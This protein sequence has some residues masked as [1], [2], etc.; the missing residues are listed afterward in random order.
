MKL[1]TRRAALRAAQAVAGLTVTVV[2]C[3]PA[4]PPEA[5][6]VPAS[7]VPIRPVGPP[8]SLSATPSHEPC[9]V[10]VD[11]FFPGEDD[12]Q[13]E[14]HI[15]APPDVERCCL[16]ALR[17]QTTEATTPDPAG[18]LI[19]NRHRWACCT[20]VDNPKNSGL[21][22]ACTPWGPPVPPPMRRR[23]LVS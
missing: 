17:H 14:K 20:A 1:E 13:P 12:Y 19:F 15:T 11:R 22:S 2:A 7:D 16:V 21:G 18:P 9:S 3:S 6:N 4:P 8:L 10:I 5:A 23:R